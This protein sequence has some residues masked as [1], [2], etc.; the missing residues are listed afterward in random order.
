MF[1][2]S[3]DHTGGPADPAAQVA[4]NDLAVGKIVDEISHSKYWK[5]SAIFVVEDDSQAGADHVD[6]HRAPIQVISPWARHG[7]VDHALLLA[8]HDGPHDRADPRRP[9]AEPEGRRGHP[10]V[11]R[12]QTKAG[13]HA[14]HGGAEPVPLTESV[15]TPPACGL[16]HPGPGAPRPPHGHRVPA[17]SVPTAAAWDNVGQQAAPHRHG[18]AGRLRQPGADEPLHLVPD[19]RLDDA[20]PGLTPRSTSPA[21]CRAAPSRRP[22][23]TDPSSQAGGLARPIVGPCGS[24]LLVLGLLLATVPGADASATADPRWRFY[25]RATRRGTPARGSRARTA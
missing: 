21:R 4:D 3:S 6:G 7:K 17:A 18:G 8:D 13:L 1:W 12:V 2:L 25:I 5:D 19:P 9:A 24:L 15:A 16:G 22:T 10:D 23:S 14:V 11:R 20:L